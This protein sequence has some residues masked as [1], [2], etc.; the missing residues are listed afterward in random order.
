MR[1]LTNFCIPGQSPSFSEGLAVLI[2]HQWISKIAP[3]E[4]FPAYLQTSSVIV[5]L[6][7]EYLAAGYIDLQLNGCGGVMFNDDPT[8]NTL[9]T[10]HQTNI[11]FGCTSFLPTLIT[12][13]DATIE[14]AIAATKQAMIEMPESVL[15]LH[16]EGPWLNPGR[17]GIHDIDY[18]RP[19]S[20]DLLRYICAHAD[21]VKK[22]TLA[23][24]IAGLEVIQQLTEAGILVSL[25][26]SLASAQQAKQGFDAGAGFVTHLYNAMPPITGREPG[27]A[28]QS[29]I[30]D[31]IFCG[32]IADGHHV[33]FSNVAMAYHM[34]GERLVLVTDATAA[35]GANID[36]FTFVN[37]KVWVRDGKCVD[38]QGTI[39]G[40]ALTMDEAVKG[41]VNGAQIRLESALRMA[42]LSA[43]RSLHMSDKFGSVL[44]G[45]IANL[46]V[47][48]E[49]LNISQTWVAGEQVFSC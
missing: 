23:P 14:Q 25:G 40:S 42:S 10:M 32:I 15:G 29:L 3:L 19:P 44:A 49:T 20:M 26:H 37:T 22:V 33:A 41:A 34:L 7:G 12:S 47:L 35:A 24:E 21:V 45:H 11:R 2:E 27:L 16:L 13:S 43:A 39:G 18:V 28:G 6:N 4:S 30:T 17:K 31:D 1:L 8:I 38:G 46:V 9:R 48:D 36:S 5:D